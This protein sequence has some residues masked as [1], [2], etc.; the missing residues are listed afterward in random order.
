MKIGPKFQDLGIESEEK[1]YEFLKGLYKLLLSGGTETHDLRE[2]RLHLASEL[3]HLL[4]QSI[5]VDLSNNGLPRR[6]T[7]LTVGESSL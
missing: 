4:S 3:L 2:G 6:Q 1:I 5:M 7:L